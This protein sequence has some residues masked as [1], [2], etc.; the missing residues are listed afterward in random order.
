MQRELHKLL[1]DHII[2]PIRYSNWMD[3]LILFRKNN[4]D[5]LIFI[6]FK[7]LDFASLKD[8]YTL[9]SMEHMLHSITRLRMMSM[10][11]RLLGYNQVL[12]LEGDMDK[13]SFTILGGIM[14]KLGLPLV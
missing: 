2:T 8:N 11:N 12:V 3:N 1:E 6:E 5:I 10:L 13:I 7:N 14:L 9:P 4:G